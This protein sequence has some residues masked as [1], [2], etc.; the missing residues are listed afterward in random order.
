MFKIFT[1]LVMGLVLTTAAQASYIVASFNTPDMNPN[2]P[3]RIMVAGSGDDLG[4]LFQEV[5]KAKALKYSEQNP[6]EQILFIA[7]N[8]K[9]LGSEWALKKWGF[10]ILKTDKSTLDG[11]VFINELAPFKKILSQ[12]FLLLVVKCIV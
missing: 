11:Q 3:T 10:K 5:A 8:E 6:G 4:L 12:I 7:A 2:R 1:S 9:E